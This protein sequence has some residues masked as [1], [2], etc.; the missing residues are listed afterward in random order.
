M[1][2]EEYYEDSKET[3]KVSNMILHTI[4]ITNILKKEHNISH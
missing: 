1:T 4:R 3:L 2:R